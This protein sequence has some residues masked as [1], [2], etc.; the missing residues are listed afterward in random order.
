MLKRVLV[1]IPVVLTS[2]AIS[3]SVAAEPQQNQP[4]TSSAQ[5]EHEQPSQ[6]GMADM[7]KM[8]QQMMAEMK[9]ADAKLDQLLSRMNA[10]TGDAKASSL[11]DVVTELARQQKA[12]HQRMSTMHDQMMMGGRGMMTKKP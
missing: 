12:M 4:S 8:H 5:H 11:A 2:Y 1:M 3:S 6:A 10:A 9:T 7:M